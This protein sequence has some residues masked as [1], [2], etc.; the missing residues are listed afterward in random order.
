MLLD[1]EQEHDLEM[2]ELKRLLNAE[3][4]KV[5][6]YEIVVQAL[7]MQQSRISK[8]NAGPMNGGPLT[9]EM[10]ENKQTGYRNHGM[11]RHGSTS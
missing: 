5:K 3:L 1:R 10:L 2:I 6:D 8:E 4:K 11:V 9:M 7:F